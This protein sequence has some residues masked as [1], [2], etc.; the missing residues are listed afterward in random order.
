MIDK[1]K[2]HGITF[3]KKEEEDAVEILRIINYYRISVYTLFLDNSSRTFTRLMELYDFDRFLWVS[4]ANLLNPLEEFLKTSLAYYIGNNYP[5]DLKGSYHP[6]LGYL[7]LSIYKSPSK[8]EKLLCE[9]YETV[10]RNIDREESLQHH[11]EHYGGNL[12]IWVLSEHLTLRNVS[13]FVSYLKRSIRKNWIEASLV[14]R[15]TGLE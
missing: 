1:L 9:L 7:D 4:I 8:G 5:F 2:D 13:S 12:P 11:I 15:K 14:N 10:S 3:T 6:S